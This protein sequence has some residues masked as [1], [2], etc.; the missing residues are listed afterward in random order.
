MLKGPELLLFHTGILFKIV[1]KPFDLANFYQKNI[2]K[3]F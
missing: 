2:L 3:I 1:L